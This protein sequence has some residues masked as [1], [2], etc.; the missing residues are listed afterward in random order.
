MPLLGMALLLMGCTAPQPKPA[1]KQ[2]AATAEQ[3]APPKGADAAAP[4][5]MEKVTAAAEEHDSGCGQEDKTAF[6][7]PELDKSK[8]GAPRYVCDKKEVESTPVWAGERLTFNF[9]IGN[10][11]TG[12]LAVKLRGG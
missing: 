11:G 1:T 5:A 8:P 9:T 7:P 12:D 6:P 2:A 10:Q 4:Q 3:A